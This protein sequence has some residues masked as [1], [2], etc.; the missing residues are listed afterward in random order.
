[1]IGICISE[2]LYYL[3]IYC[4]KIKVKIFLYKG[5]ILDYTVGAVALDAIAESST[6]SIVITLQP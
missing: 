6:F 3:E 1:M 2:N 4:L 5:L